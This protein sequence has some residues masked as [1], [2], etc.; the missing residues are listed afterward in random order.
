MGDTAYFL[1]ETTAEDLSGGDDEYVE[2]AGEG[3]LLEGL[4]A[5]LRELEDS[6]Y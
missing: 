6:R 1:R 5:E 3:K 4:A 2:W